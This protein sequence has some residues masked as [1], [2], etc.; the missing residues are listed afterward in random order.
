MSSLMN[1]SPEVITA[2]ST[3]TNSVTL[4]K[5]AVCSSETPRQKKGIGAETQK[6][7]II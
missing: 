4:K 2:A 6:L 7:T 5:K 1:C 3:Q